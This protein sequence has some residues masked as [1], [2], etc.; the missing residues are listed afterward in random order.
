MAPH[1]ADEVKYGIV[2]K[3]VSAVPGSQSQG[4]EGRRPGDPRPRHG[5]RR[6]R[7]GGGWH[8]GPGARLIKQARAGR[9]GGKPGLG[10]S[11]CAT[12]SRRWTRC[13]ANSRK[14]ANTTRRSDRAPHFLVDVD[15]DAAGKHRAPSLQIRLHPGVAGDLL[16]VYLEAF[17]RL[18]FDLLDEFCRVVDVLQQAYAVSPNIW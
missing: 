1:C 15:F 7:H 10:S 18:V 9:G 14:S 17:G 2:D 13:C 12:C 11:A 16:A 8:L 5:Q 6:A 3:V 4:R